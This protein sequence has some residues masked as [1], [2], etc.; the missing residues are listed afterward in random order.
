[1]EFRKTV[2]EI[3]HGTDKFEYRITSEE[4]F[5]IF[6]AIVLRKFEPWR[7]ELNRNVLRIVESRLMWLVQPYNLMPENRNPYRYAGF[8]KIS[9]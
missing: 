6:P 2:F 4:M 5:D 9:V 3:I 8:K 7:E 1:M